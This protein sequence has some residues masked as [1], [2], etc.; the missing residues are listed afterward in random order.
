MPPLMIEVVI[1]DLRQLQ[2]PLNKIH[3]EM[4]GLAQSGSP[5]TYHKKQ[6]QLVS[7]L[8]V[9]ALLVLVILFAGL[10]SGW[11]LFGAMH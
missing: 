8:I 1:K 3:S 2:V 10:R 4:F 7:R 11:K 5:I 9:L 6:A